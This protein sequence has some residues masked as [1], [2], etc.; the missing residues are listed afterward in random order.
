M[1]ARE[2]VQIRRNADESRYE[3]FVGTTLAGFMQYAV[4][5]R[6]ADFIHTEIADEFGGRGLAS[7]LIRGALDDARREEWKVVPSC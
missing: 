6:R 1:T 3:I 7:Q 4:H 2:D 5:G